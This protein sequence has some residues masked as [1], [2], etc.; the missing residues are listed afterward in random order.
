MS[1][2]DNIKTAAD[3]ITE[4]SLNGLST[5]QDDLNRAADIFGR[6]SIK[7]LAAL[8]NDAQC[9]S[10]DGYSTG[11]P[12]TSS[13]FYFIAFSVW[14]WEE[15]TRFY[16]EHTLLL[17]TKYREATD[18]LKVETKR[19]DQATE[20]WHKYEASS[21]EQWNAR[22]ATEDALEAAQQEI[23][24]LKAKLYDLMTAGA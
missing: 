19:A 8:A 10:E 15:A 3:L 13:T 17:P 4:V 23:V 16:N 24:A 18:K 12:S 9:K 14:N 2:Y 11:K 5:A 20:N 1:K 21:K 7:D 6:S 22:R